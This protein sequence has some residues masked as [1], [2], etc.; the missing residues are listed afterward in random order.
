VVNASGGAAASG[1]RSRADVA[2]QRARV[3]ARRHASEAGYWSRE[4]PAADGASGGG[5]LPA[6]WS[7]VAHGAC[8]NDP[9]LLK[10]GGARWAALA[11]PGGGAGPEKGPRRRG[12]SGPAGASLDR[13]RRSLTIGE[14]DGPLPLGARPPP[15]PGTAGA[16]GGAVGSPR[17]VLRE[18]AVGPPG[19]AST[20]RLTEAQRDA[21]LAA[22]PPRHRL[23]ALANNLDRDD[24]SP[25]FTPWTEALDPALDAAAWRSRP[26]RCAALGLSALEHAMRCHLE[27]LSRAECER[28]RAPATGPRDLLRVAFNAVDVG[29]TGRVSLQQFLQC[30]QNV[31]E[32]RRYT[33]TFA[34][35][36]SGRAGGRGS[37]RRVR[38]LVR[39][40]R[41]PMSRAAA[42]AVFVRYGFDAEGLLPWK[43]F[44]EAL[45]CPPARLAGFEPLVD[46]AGRGANGLSCARDVAA[47]AA[48]GRVLYPKSRSTAQAPQGFLPETAARSRKGPRAR[49]FLDHVYGIEGNDNLANNLFYNWRGEPSLPAARRPRPS[50]RRPRAPAR[51]PAPPPVAP[52]PRPSPRARA[53]RPAPAPASA[54]APAAAGPGPGSRARR[55]ASPP[56]APQESSSTTR[57]AWASCTAARGRPAGS[58]PSASSSATRTTS[59]ASACTRGAGW[60]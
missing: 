52:R 36:G 44:A 49:L 9:R 59:S 51:R 46:A 38:T 55:T 20:P 27:S 60:W 39:G 23:H 21:L 40:P 17:R 12:P 30:W 33:E 11:D 26:A 53:R 47:A 3:E 1:G 31:L 6:F 54:P 22:M 14:A 8:W 4:E 41:L 50:P 56:P 24:R 5:H 13:L 25:H 58:A 42:A 16:D 18:G 45:C 35:A 2:A 48:G 34:P 19:D 43:V 32:L 15:R 29:R 7:E 10:G 28:A 37:H 57:R